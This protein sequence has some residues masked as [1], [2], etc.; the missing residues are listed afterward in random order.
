[1]DTTFKKPSVLN[2][3][4]LEEEIYLIMESERDI[5]KNWT[6]DAREA[7]VKWLEFIN[8]LK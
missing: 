2:V 3:T 6:M 8:N 7:Y 4:T 5:K 1:M